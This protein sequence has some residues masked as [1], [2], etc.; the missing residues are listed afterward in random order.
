MHILLLNYTN[1]KKTLGHF[2]NLVFVIMSTRENIRLIARTSLKRFK[3]CLPF[4]IR[5]YTSVTYQ[6]YLIV[7][8]ETFLRSFAGG[9][10][11]TRVCLLSTWA[12]H[13]LLTYTRCWYRRK[14]RLQKFADQKNP[15]APSYVHTMRPCNEKTSVFVV[16]IRR[17]KIAPVSQRS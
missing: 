2:E 13:S 15:L 1:F 3:I 5:C 6:I 4:Q 8:M 16:C 10:R 14:V 11:V 12:E 17:T 9:L 7:Y